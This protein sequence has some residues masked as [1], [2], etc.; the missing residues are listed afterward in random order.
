[1]EEIKQDITILRYINQAE[2]K[3]IGY[4]AFYVDGFNKFYKNLDDIP[5]VYEGKAL[6]G[7]VQVGVK[8]R[9]KYGRERR[10]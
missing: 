7:L 1:M 5:N 2:S 10:K 9:N 4:Q 3:L 6:R 8:K